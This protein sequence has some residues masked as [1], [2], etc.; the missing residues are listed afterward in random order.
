MATD[1]LS[2]AE[3][4][5]RIGAS[6]IARIGEL[7]RR[8]QNLLAEQKQLT[9][10]LAHYNQG[11]DGEQRLSKEVLAHI[12]RW[13]HLDW[14]LFADRH[15]PRTRNGNIDLIL[16]GPPGVLVLDAKA[17]DTSRVENGRLKHGRFDASDHVRS[18]R[19]QARSLDRILSA[20]GFPAGQ[21]KPVLVLVNSGERDKKVR[22]VTV[23]GLAKL[24]EFLMSQRTTLTQGQIA[25]IAN[26]LGRSL[27]PNLQAEPMN[28]DPSNESS[29]LAIVTPDLV[30]AIQSAARA[31]DIE[32]WMCWLH[33]E[34]ARLTAMSFSG[35]A[36]LRG[37]AGTGKT[38]V[39]L[40]RVHALAG[41][42]GARILMVAPTR[43]LSVL[44]EHLFQ[45]LGSGR[46]GHVEFATVHSWCANYLKQRGQTFDA[47][48]G[49]QAFNRA[50]G[51]FGA[52][53]KS[54]LESV[55]VTQQYWRDEIRHVIQ[56]RALSSLE[57]YGELER[58]GRRVP[59]RE[60]HRR[61]VWRLF[62]RY[63]E[64]KSV[65]GIWDW[66]DVIENTWTAL[67]EDPSPPV[68]T[69]VIVDEVQDLS[70]VAVRLIRTLA[71]EG[72][73]S[74]LLVG[75]GRQQVFPG[76]FRLVEAGI[77]IPGSRSIVL[78][79]N[80][81]NGGRIAHCARSVLVDVQL[82]NLDDDPSVSTRR[83][84]VIKATGEVVEREFAGREAQSF[85]MRDYIRDQQ[86]AGVSWGAIAV[87]VASTVEV[88]E[89]VRLLTKFNMP[90]MALDDCN[91]TRSDKVKVGTYERSKGLEFPVVLLPSVPR[92]SKPLVHE[93]SA[94]MQEHRELHA[95]RLYVAMTRAV[96]NLWIG[97]VAPS[98]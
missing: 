80:Y 90:V 31:G 78:D 8:V 39:A 94:Q 98:A 79:V 26:L 88:A 56:G 16:V 65:L 46:I 73:D 75:D 7:E 66:E 54:T 76:G 52:N 83:T 20:E 96:E 15:W 10:E 9:L 42:P 53:A 84:K 68:F 3:E 6:G 55:G 93:E 30:M 59:L 50:W 33:P 18:V 69:S 57:E 43:N 49:G 1:P 12:E 86:C 60:H 17:W 36:R 34:Q 25:K 89:M 71:Q 58:R 24:S 27:P 61:A 63:R 2:A 72:P 40:H 35:P 62:E 11:V 77:T 32:S 87:L 14:Y 81:R 97:R 64:S 28:W 38:V 95:Q 45:R 47:D 4:V 91:G 44:H 13:Q 67:V 92:V 70:L 74:L 85:A 21:T 51:K 22:G 19:E 37:G 5:K 23:V 41:V 82:P 29:R 48:D